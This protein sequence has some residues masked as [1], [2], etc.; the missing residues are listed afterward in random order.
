M[1]AKISVQIGNTPTLTFPLTISGPPAFNGATA[2]DIST[3]RP[4]LS[5]AS[6]AMIAKT[7]ADEPVSRA[8]FRV[9]QFLFH[10]RNRHNVDLAGN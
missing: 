8:S 1:A 3:S 10:C 7:T 2:S 9:G 5:A 6:Q 4:R